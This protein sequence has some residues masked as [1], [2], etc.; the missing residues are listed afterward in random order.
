MVNAE[1]DPGG[2]FVGQFR[3]GEH[4]VFFQVRQLRFE[5]FGGHGQDHAVTF[6]QDAKA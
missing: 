2:T 6:E 4:R 3:F 1:A 5:Q